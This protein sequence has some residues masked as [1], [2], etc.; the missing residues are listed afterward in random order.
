MVPALF[1][2]PKN[3]REWSIFSFANRASHEK[4]ISALQ[5]QGKG[6]LRTYNLDPI[7]DEDLQGWMYR[8]QISHNDFNGVLKLPS[9]DLR[10]ADFK[11]PKE[12]QAWCELHAREHLLAEK[13]LAG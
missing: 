4:I 3:P 2:T 11:D 8:H 13:A 6:T 10:T 5:A 7:S 12:L 9:N 1:N